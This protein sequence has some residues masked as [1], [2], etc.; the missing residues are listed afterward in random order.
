MKKRCGRSAMTSSWIVETNLIGLRSQ[1]HK[2]FNFPYFKAFGLQ[3]S[4]TGLVK[5]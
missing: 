5:L 1:G 4:F 2:M 3:V